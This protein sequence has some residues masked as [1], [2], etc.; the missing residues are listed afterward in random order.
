MKEYGS[1]QD[2][3]KNTS[4]SSDGEVGCADISEQIWYV[5]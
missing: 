3:S 2:I 5:P 4:R 1:D